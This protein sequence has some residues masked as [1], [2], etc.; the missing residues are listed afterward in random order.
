MLRHPAGGGLGDAVLSLS[1]R[2]SPWPR[3]ARSA[4]L[5]HQQIAELLGR[6]CSFPSQRID[7]TCLLDRLPNE[8]L[9]HPGAAIHRRG[10]AHRRP[11]PRRRCEAENST[12]T[13]RSIRRP[14]KDPR[15]VRRPASRGRSKCW[16][17]SS[18]VRPGIGHRSAPGRSPRLEGPQARDLLVSDRHRP[19]DFLLGRAAPDAET[20]GAL[21]RSSRPSAAGRRRARARRRCGPSRSTPPIHAGQQEA[22]ALHPLEASVEDARQARLGMAVQVHAERAEPLSELLAQPL[23]ARR[24]RVHR[25]AGDQEGLAHADDLMRRERARRSP[26]L[27]RRGSGAGA[28]YARGIEHTIPSA[29]RTLCA[30]AISCTGSV[31]RSIGSLPA[32]CAAWNVEQD[33]R[34]R[35]ARRSPRCPTT[36]ISLLA[37]RWRRARCRRAAPPRPPPA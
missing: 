34:R 2:A 31:L 10:N 19:V 33:A 35:R 23:D 36:P 26:C 24:L 27:R 22:L 30:E 1:C 16:R 29:V 18:A 11:G 5:D 17:T 6:T 37:C 25:F 4:V 12:H 13:P 15:P 28:Q 20:K 3:Q 21:R 8:L 14:L 32:L 7:P 9:R